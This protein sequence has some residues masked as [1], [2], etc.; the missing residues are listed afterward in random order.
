MRLDWIVFSQ[1]APYAALAAGMSLCLYLFFSLKR[2]VR[3]VDERLGRRA[4]AF[5]ADWTARSGELDARWSQLSHISKFL[6]EPPPAAS[7][8]NLT[9]RS[10]AL[11]LSKRGASIEDIASTLSLR[12]NEVELLVK[13][14]KLTAA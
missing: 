13:I 9:K 12:R 3:S 7:G 10:Q 4:S 6:V 1:T 2:D 5:E 14:Q 8:L 11:Q